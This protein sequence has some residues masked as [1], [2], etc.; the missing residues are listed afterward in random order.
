MNM[1][2]APHP[3]F[4]SWFKRFFLRAWFVSAALFMLSMFLSK[5]DFSV[6]G[7]ILAI[8]FGISIVFTLGYL[9]YRLYHID[10]P[11]CH[12]QLK[13]IKNIKLSKYEAICDQCKVVW[14]TG[15][16]IGNGD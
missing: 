6:I 10:C 14:D 16:G 12:A 3:N 2:Y 7:S 5:N 11:N 9:L 13:T 15:I 4:G 8:S 1:N